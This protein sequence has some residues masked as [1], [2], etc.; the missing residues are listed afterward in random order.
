MAKTYKAQI[1]TNVTFF[2]MD[3]PTPDY[4]DSVLRKLT[5]YFHKISKKTSEIEK[6][7]GGYQKQQLEQA[8]K[9]L[10]DDVENYLER[11]VVSRAQGEHVHVQVLDRSSPLKVP[12]IRVWRNDSVV[13]ERVNNFQHYKLLRDHILF[14][15]YADAWDHSQ[16]DYYSPTESE[17]SG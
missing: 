9:E 6:A 13:N 3:I 8:L 15:S 1:S 5:D 16:D 4:V 2:Q 14:T 17:D 10:I 7:T 12:N 11:E